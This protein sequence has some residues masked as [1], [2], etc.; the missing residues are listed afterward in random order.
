MLWGDYGSGKTHMLEATEQ[1]ALERGFAVARLTLDPS[2]QALHHPLRLY[3]S[4]MASVRTL[5]QATPGFEPIFEELADNA[6]HRDPAG[7]HASRF[8]SPYLHALHAGDLEAIGWLRDYV[9]GDRMD[10]SDVNRVLGNLG[11]RGARVLAMSD[12]RTYGRMYVHLV[13]TL[14]S[15]CADAGH[16]GLVLLF[17]EVERVDAL[18]FSNQD[19]AFEVLRHFAAVTMDPKDLAFDPEGLYKGGHAVHKK[20]PLRFRPDQ[21]L[22][23]VF[24]L[25]PLEKIE[26]AFSTVTSSP[27]YDV[28]LE[29]LARASLPILVERI[30][31]LYETAYPGF[32]VSPPLI[33]RI[34]GELEDALDDGHDRFRDAVRATVFLLDGERCKGAGRTSA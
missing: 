34:A 7:E 29:P 9:G 8:F 27:E 21:P 33:A 12:F 6:S 1:L 23:S 10:S 18:S 25:T 30:G 15:W 2:E 26:R 22:V 31:T 24:A 19:Y 11:W 3:R 28:L 17:D 4:I 20:I 32:E 14:A 5:G 16:R 13:G